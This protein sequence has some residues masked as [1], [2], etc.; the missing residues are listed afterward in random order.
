MTECIVGVELPEK[1]PCPVCGSDDRGYCRKAISI[2]DQA[3]QLVLQ[4]AKD[5]GLWFVAQTA[6]EAYLQ[7]EL[8]RLHE[9]IEGKSSI[10]CALTALAKAKEA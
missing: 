5:N 6:P 9:T 7:H 1:G 4:Q 2:Y 10:E 8:R 3:R